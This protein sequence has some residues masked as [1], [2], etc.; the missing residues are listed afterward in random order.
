MSVSIS[1]KKQGTRHKLSVPCDLR[2]I[3]FFGQVISNNAGGVEIMKLHAGSMSLATAGA[4]N[5]DKGCTYLNA[6][7]YLKETPHCRQQQSLEQC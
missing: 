1:A 5:P 7:M 2:C 6:V 3:P 4:W